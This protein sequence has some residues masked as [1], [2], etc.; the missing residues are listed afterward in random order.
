V[1]DVFCIAMAL[2]PMLAKQRSSNWKLTHYMWMDWPY[3]GL[4]AAA[5]TE[6]RTRTQP[7]SGSGGIDR[8]DAPPACAASRQPT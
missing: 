3:L 2:W 5:R 6:S 8:R 4:L 7:Q 1:A